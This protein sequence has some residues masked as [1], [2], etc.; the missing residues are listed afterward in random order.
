MSLDK[1]SSDGKEDGASSCPYFSRG[2]RRS[3]AAFPSVRMILVGSLGWRPCHRGS[4]SIEL[5]QAKCLRSK[6]AWNSLLHTILPSN[7]L[8][9]LSFKFKFTPSLQYTA[10][11]GLASIGLS[12]LQVSSLDFLMCEVTVVSCCT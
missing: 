1:I 12:L 8:A 10:C 6:F 5:C 11:A 9:S 3:H 4:L 2:L 7:K